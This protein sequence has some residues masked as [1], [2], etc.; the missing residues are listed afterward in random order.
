[1]RLTTR[2]SVFL[3]LLGADE[4]P[5]LSPLRSQR[6]SLLRRRIRKTLRSLGSWAQRRQAGWQEDWRNSSFPAWGETEPPAIAPGRG[7]TQASGPPASRRLVTMLPSLPKPPSSEPKL[8]LQAE[9]TVK[10]LSTLLSTAD[11]P[12]AKHPEE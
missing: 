9:P 4:E 11:T 12:E 5:V 6:C 2:A 10:F 3:S 8:D 1:M 7:R